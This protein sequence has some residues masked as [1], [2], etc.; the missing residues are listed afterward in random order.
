LAAVDAMFEPLSP[1]AAAGMPATPEPP[2]TDAGL[3][4]VDPQEDTDRPAAPA[5]P[6]PPTARPPGAA[7]DLP[8]EI[9]V[10][11]QLM[12]DG[13]PAAALDLLNAMVGTHPGDVALRQLVVNAENDFCRQLLDGEFP[14]SSVPVRDDDF[15]PGNLSAEEAFILQQ[16]D[17]HTNVQSL[18]WIAPMR[19]VDTLKALHHMARTGCIRVPAAEA[20]AGS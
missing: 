14:L 3:P 7:R 18:L 9:N 10:A 13:K 11:L 16:I 4:S 8:A 6:A 2:A 19:D 12:A 20:A 1:P 17:G 15:P 5:P